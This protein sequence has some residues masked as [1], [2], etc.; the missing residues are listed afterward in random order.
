MFMSPTDKS[1]KTQKMSLWRWF[2]LVSAV[3]VVI[4]LT[5]VILLKPDYG[6]LKAIC[7]LLGGIAWIFIL[8]EFGILKSIKNNL[9]PS[10]RDS[11]A[12]ENSVS[13]RT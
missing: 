10:H 3:I 5:A 13:N 11:P 9:D 7:S 8:R 2:V 12:T 6:D 1:T 4:S